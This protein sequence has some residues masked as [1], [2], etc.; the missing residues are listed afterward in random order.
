M[1][2]LD[3]LQD[4]FLRLMK[5]FLDVNSPGARLDFLACPLAHSSDA[6]EIAQFLEDLINVSTLYY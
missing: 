4:F 2:D 3:D 1:K 6:L 5:D